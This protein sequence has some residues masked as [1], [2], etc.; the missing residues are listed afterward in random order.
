MTSELKMPT[1]PFCRCALSFDYSEE[2]GGYLT[3]VRVRC[4]NGKCPVMPIGKWHSIKDSPF[5]KNQGEWESRGDTEAKVAK[6]W[7]R[8]APSAAVVRLVEACRNIIDPTRTL[9]SYTA[10]AAVLSAALE[11]VEK[12]IGQ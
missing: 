5:H 9:A 3:G 12:E 4:T 7:N 2:G 1:C 11:A 6:A 8:R 10:D